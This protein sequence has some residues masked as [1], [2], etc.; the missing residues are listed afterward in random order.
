MYIYVAIVTYVCVLVYVHVHVAIICDRIYK[1]VL[2]LIHKSDS[3]TLM[4]HS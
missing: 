3:S 4:S 2:A 1:K